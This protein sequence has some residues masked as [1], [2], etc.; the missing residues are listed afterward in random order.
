[1][2]LRSDHKKYVRQQ[3]EAHIECAGGEEVRVLATAGGRDLVWSFR[4]ESG[5]AG[6]YF[7]C[8]APILAC[9]KVWPTE[10]A[11]LR[12][13]VSCACQHGLTEPERAEHRAQ[14]NPS[15]PATHTYTHT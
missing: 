1:M 3:A 7:W 5:P 12:H 6:G 8:C 2:S 13:L 9:R 11:L 14:T 4:A 10:P 15:P